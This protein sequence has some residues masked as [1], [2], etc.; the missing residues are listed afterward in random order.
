VSG[1]SGN[2]VVFMAHPDDAGAVVENNILSTYRDRFSLA[3]EAANTEGGD[4]GFEATSDYHLT[5]GSPCVDTGIADH[6][7]NVDIDG[8]PRPQGGGVDRGA[9]ER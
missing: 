3:S 4:P 8:E 1:T 6:A 7:P 9:Y 5:A 2:R